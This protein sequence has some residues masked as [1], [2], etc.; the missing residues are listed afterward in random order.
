MTNASL[1][2][3]LHPNGPMPA[4]PG[5]ERRHF[6]DRDG[7]W[8]G[9]AGWIQ[10]DAGDVSGW[11]HHAVNDTYVYVMRGSVTVEFGRGGSE[12]IVA[13][14]GDFFIVPADTVHR[15]LTGEG[16]DLEAF[17][18]RVG[19]E[20]EEVAADGPEASITTSGGP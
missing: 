16:S 9:W 20:P 13:G 3:V 1:P 12:R 5:P 6:H 7:R 18:V 14:P 10:N 11:H 19:G 2:V 8:V 17:I 15:E 4:P